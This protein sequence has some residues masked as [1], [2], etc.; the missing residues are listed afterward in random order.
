MTEA[1]S[2]FLHFVKLKIRK[3]TSRIWDRD[4]NLTDPISGKKNGTISIRG[5]ETEDRGAVFTL[6][7]AHEMLFYPQK[8][9]SVVKNGV[10]AVAFDSRP[11]LFVPRKSQEKK[12][13]L[14]QKDFL[15]SRTLE[16]LH[17]VVVFLFLFLTYFSWLCLCEC[18]I[19][20][21]CGT[22]VVPGVILSDWFF[23]EWQQIHLYSNIFFEFFF[24]FLNVGFVTEDT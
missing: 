10:F 24:F 11:C 12:I 14:N 7:I 4:L 8:Y 5:S 21:M 2:Y 15:F 9:K 16:N 17:L 3:S 13:N 6:L 22:P 18:I 19:C 20:F 23:N 1:F